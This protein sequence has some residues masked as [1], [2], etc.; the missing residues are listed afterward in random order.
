ME[1]LR[2]LYRIGPG[3]SSSHTLAPQKACK[4]YMEYY[5]NAIFFDVSLYGSLALT[6]VGHATDEI[7]KKTFAPRMCRVSFKD[8][9]LGKF[10]NG[11]VIKGYNSL[12]E[13]EKEWTV[14]SLGGGSIDVEEEDLKLH[15]EIYPHNFMYEILEYCQEKNISLAEYPYRFEKDIDR[16]LSDVLNQMLRTVDQGLNTS[17]ILPGRLKLSR[18]AK[19]LHLQAI[20]IDDLI[21]KQK[22]LLASYAYAACEENADGKTCVAAPTMGASGIL[23]A[24]VYYYYH[25]YG[26]SRTKLLRG[27]AIAGIFGNIVKKNATISGAVGGCQAEVG[28]AC[29]M[30]SAMIAYFNGLSNKLIAYA[31]EIGMEHHLG[32]TCDPVGGYVMIPCIERNAV[33]TMRAMDSAI[34]AQH[35]GMIKANRVSFDDVVR[36]MQYTGKKIPIELRET[37]LGGLATEIGQSEHQQNDKNREIEVKDIKKDLLS[38]YRS[39]D[40]FANLEIDE[41]DIDEIDNKLNIKI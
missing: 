8:R 25:D 24:L 30:G 27:L 35:V 23:A 36:T 1:S 40:L 19:A 14:Y 15:T 10:P 11:L 32:L 22:I 12:N 4:M 26:L 39:S 29:A 28:T 17:G 37:S 7:I 6:G 33:A 41:T 38:T 9:A 34:L 21:E 2:E 20:S 16:Y 3:P 31:A 5:P 13:L 18:I